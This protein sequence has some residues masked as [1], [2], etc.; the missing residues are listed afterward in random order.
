VPD[1]E[2]V[3]QTAPVDDVQAQPD[4]VVTVIV[5]VLPAGGTETR[6]GETENVHD[7]LGSVTTKLFPA[8][9][10]VAVLAS[11]VVLA[12]AVNPTLP[13]P[14]PFAPLVIVTQ[15]A[16]LDAVQVQPVVVETETMLLPPFADIDR[17][18]GV[19]VYE[20]EAAAWVTVK[21]LPPIVRIP[22]REVVVVLAATL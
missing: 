2:S 1:A 5:P 8:I 19:M 3:I 21:V 7:A 20:Q 14:V 22:V 13:E 15:D 4:W 16:P 11:D 12:A 10:S 9:V 17:L 6:I 18:V